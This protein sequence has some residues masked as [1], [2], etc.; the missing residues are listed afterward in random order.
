M[1]PC[2]IVGLTSL[3]A[4]LLSLRDHVGQRARRAFARVAGVAAF[5]PA[6][7]LLRTWFIVGLVGAAHADTVLCWVRAA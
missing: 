3:V 2:R 1:A 5:G 7:L 6:G 4:V